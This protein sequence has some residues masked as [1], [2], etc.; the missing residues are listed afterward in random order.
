MQILRGVP[1]APFGGM[2][3]TL[4]AVML[5]SAL[6]LA[7]DT[8]K[9]KLAEP[10]YLPP[11]A[12]QLLRSRMQRHGDEMVELVMAVTLLQRERAKALADDLAAEPRLTRPIAGGAGDLNTALP[13]QLFVWQDELRVRAKAPRRRHPQAVGRRAGHRVRPSH[14][15]LR[16]VPLGVSAPGG[17]AALNVER[18]LLHLKEP[19]EPT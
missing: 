13:E 14:R 6:A 19:Q 1:V 2:K 18:G 5:L 4:L 8:P 15:D 11:L 3:R 12:R 9:R 7:A 10:D 16:L 17:R